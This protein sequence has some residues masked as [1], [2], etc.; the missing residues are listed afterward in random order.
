MIEIRGNILDS[1][2]YTHDG[3]PI[4]IYPDAICFTSNEVIKKNGALVMGAGVA[5]V[6]RDYYQGLDHQA[7]REVKANGNICQ[8][9]D[10]EERWDIIAFPTKN[11]WRN[12]SNLSLIVKSAIQLRSI[13]DENEWCKV[14]LPR[15]G[16]ANGG[17]DWNVVKPMLESILDDRVFIITL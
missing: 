3:K 8:I 17:L 14:V 16:C 10:A 5:K 12:L 9:I 2:T 13:I 11:H 4:L 1:T 6:F 7:G 15:P